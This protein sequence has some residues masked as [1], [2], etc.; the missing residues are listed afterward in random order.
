MCILA[1]QSQISF[2]PRGTPNFLLRKSTCPLFFFL[3]WVCG[4]PPLFFPLLWFVWNILR[5]RAFAAILPP[6]IF[7]YFTCPLSLF[8]TLTPLTD[9]FLGEWFFFISFLINTICL[10][11][12]SAAPRFI[13]TSFSSSPPIPHRYVPFLPT[14]RDMSI[15]SSLF[16]FGGHW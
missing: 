16:F 6:P 1:P 14:W 12:G 2:S 13:L 10:F 4:F 15:E 11:R 7:G 9:Y 3:F 5:A 8:L